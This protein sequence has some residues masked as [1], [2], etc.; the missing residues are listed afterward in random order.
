MNLKIE[1]AKRIMDSAIDQYKPETILVGF[2]GGSDSLTLLHLMNE[3]GY[4]F[5]PFFCNTGIGVEEQWEFIRTH[6]AKHNFKLFEQ[7]P[8]YKLYKQII[9]QNGFPGPSMHNVIF[10]DLKM[11]SI[12]AISKYY[13]NKTIIVTGVRLTE[14]ERRKINITSEIQKKDGQ[15]WV[16]PIMNWDDDDKDEYME[17][18]EIERSPVSQNL[19]MSFECGCGAY[20][21]KGEL[22]KIRYFYPNFA[23]VIDG[24]QD[25]L[26]RIGFTWGWDDPI[27][28]LA[29]YYDVMERIYP[30]YK[31]M[32][33]Y[34]QVSR[35]TIKK[36]QT[37]LFMPMCHRCEH[38]YNL[39]M[40]KAL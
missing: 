4:N 11:K 15:V 12:T 31:E 21:V 26:F 34:K 13:D 17:T 29:E 39:K 32:K 19:G 35:H 7:K 20:A 23:R 30:G 5:I 3:L 2:T 38:N 33:L 6:C 40:Q 1:D 28:D 25:T 22:E 10:N 9:I 37:D 14:S 27:P 18:R 24:L 36:Q 16:A 8:T